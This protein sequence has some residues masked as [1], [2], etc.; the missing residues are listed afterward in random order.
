[1]PR[2]RLAAATLATLFSANVALACSTLDQAM[3]DFQQVADAFSAQAATISPDQFPIWTDKVQQFSAVMGQQDYGQACSILVEL[4]AELQL[5]VTLAH[6]GASAPAAPAATE[7]PR[8]DTGG[9]TGS[10]GDT[11]AVTPQPAAPAPAAPAAPTT[12]PA[13]QPVAHAPVTASAGQIVRGGRDRTRPPR[14]W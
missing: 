9:G 2:K 4:V 11:I 6:A 13:E 10:G 14:L 8:A 7:P 12:Q 1:M 3:S 5:D